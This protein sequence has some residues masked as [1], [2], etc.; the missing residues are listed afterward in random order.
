MREKN[1]VEI[2]KWLELIRADKVGPTTFAKLLKHFGSVDVALGASVA[3]LAK[4]DGVG[5]KTAEKITATRNKFDS[6]AELDLADKLN[7]WL[8]NLDD[9][10]YPVLLKRIYDPPPV[11]Y[12]KGSLTSSDNLGIAIVGSRRCSLYGQQQSSRFAHLLA[13]AG[14][15][16]LSGLARGIDT[17]AHRGALSAEGRTIAV[18][19]CG[20]A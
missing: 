8:I 3:E 11:L 18:Q 7:V 16:I 5:F 15:T 19:G 13:S 12:I 10:R 14:F 20:L 6:A 2:Q 9:K 4:V 1:S 17:A